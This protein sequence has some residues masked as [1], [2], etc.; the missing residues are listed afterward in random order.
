MDLVPA[1]RRGTL[2]ACAVLAVLCAAV[3]AHSLSGALLN[4]DDQAYITENPELHLP[5]GEA[6][7]AIFGTFRCANWNPLQ[8]LSYL[9]EMRA[10]GADPA[11]FR[12]TNLLFHYASSV[13]VF[14]MLSAWLR[15]RTAA[16]LAAAAFAVHPANVENAAWIAERKTLIASA[17]AFAATLA[18]LRAE[19]TG[20]LRVVALSLFAV[21]LL[22]KTSIVV[23]PALLFLLDLSLRRR[24]AWGW[25]AAFCALALP[26]GWVQVRAAAGGGGLESL[27]G[28]TVWTHVATCVAVLPRYAGSV[29]APFG[30]VPRHILDPVTS[31]GDLRTVLGAALLVL[32]AW[33]TLR[34][35]RG[36]RRFFVAAPWFLA[37]VLP[38]VIVP[39]PILQADR[40]LYLALPF[41]LGAAAGWIVPRLALA[42]AALRWAPAAALVVLGVT[43]AEYADAWRTS[44]SLWSRQIE[45]HPRDAAA[46]QSLAVARVVEA[47]DGPGA[48]ACYAQL[49]AL[50]P[51]FDDGPEGLALVDLSD[52]HPDAA[53]RAMA[54]LV[55]AHPGRPLAW[56]VLSRAYE[57]LGRLD[58]AER[59]L[60]DGLR[61]CPDDPDITAN[62]EAFRARH[63][64]RAAPR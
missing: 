52:G 40:Y 39:I 5:F 63:P 60:T 25:Y 41:L 24:P 14:F 22:A 43:A 34:S 33:G 59:A 29:I 58:E 61:S 12:V 21:G 7:S 45:R 28:G 36:E 42:P 49:L 1:T 57:S 56:S 35:W 19:G 62:L 3:Y 55:A 46:W 37:T 27:H 26:A 48:R 4:W 31:A 23:L 51:L 17:F 64:E 15:N 53:E 50:D 9:L 13:L 44:T 30:L 11:A 16:L 32:L 10:F 54:D 38:T 2:T 20:R 47:G 6:V 8:R 18:W